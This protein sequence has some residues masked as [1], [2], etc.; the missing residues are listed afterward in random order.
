MST[1]QSELVLILG[2]GPAGLGAALAFH[3]NK[4]LNIVVV[5]GRSDMNFDLENSYEVGINVRGQNAIKNLFANSANQPDMSK[6]GLRVDQ[7]KIIVGPGINVA[8]FDSGLVVG[9]TRSAVTQLLYDECKR[10]NGIQILLG[11]KAK[12]VDLERKTLVCDVNSGG[13]A[14]FE[15]SVLI[16]ADGYKSKVRD[17]LAEQS[18]VLKVQQWPW[19]DSFRVLVSDANKQTNLNP[20][21]HY[22]YNRTY[23]SKLLNGNWTGVVVSF[24]LFFF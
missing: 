11:H 17:Q 19:K 2:G 14:S 7:W 3:N 8:N 12:R 22:I 10:R 20:Y 9:T 24:L 13:E 4:Y 18:K 15:P 1:N 6:L 5:E 21:I 23:I 16:I